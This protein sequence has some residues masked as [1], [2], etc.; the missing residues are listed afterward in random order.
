MCVRWK[1]A[2]AYALLWKAEKKHAI[3]E[4][5]GSR[6]SSSKLSLVLGGDG[7]LKWAAWGGRSLLPLC[8]TA[9]ESSHV[10]CGR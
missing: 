7:Q 3:E 5:E 10:V 2:R 8:K 6:V 4:G 1:R 9:D